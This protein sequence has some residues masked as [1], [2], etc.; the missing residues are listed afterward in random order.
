MKKGDQVKILAKAVYLATKDKEGNKLEQIIN[1]FLLYLTNH[2]LNFLIPKILQQVE[3]MYLSDNNTVSAE[4]ISREKLADNELNKIITL[5]KD[6]S[7]KEVI[8]KQY[9]NEDILGGV[10]VKYEDKLLDMSLKN[11]LKKLAKRFS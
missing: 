7:K 11:Q 4:I 3:V 8:T 9:Q 6:K 10:V 2:R 1:N 5:I